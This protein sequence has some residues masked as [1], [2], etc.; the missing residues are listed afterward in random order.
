MNKYLEKIAAKTDL[1]RE[2]EKQREGHVLHHKHNGAL[3]GGYLAGA[4]Y[5]AYSLSRLLKGRPIRLNQD[6]YTGLASTVAG[7]VVG[8]AVGKRNGEKTFKPAPIEKEA[9]FKTAWNA[10]KNF[11]RT[12]PGAAKGA[13]T[14][15]VIGGTLGGL[16]KKDSVLDNKN[17][18]RTVKRTTA[19]RV[20]SALSGAVT[21]AYV[22]TVI[23]SLRDLK[24]AGGF[25]GSSGKASNEYTSRTI[26]DIHSDLSMPKGG[27]K[28]KTEAKSHFRKMRSQYHPDKHPG[29]EK[30][31][32]DKMAKFNRAWDEFE[33]HPQGFTKL[34]NAYLDKIAGLDFS[35]IK[36]AVKA[37]PV[38]TGLGAAMGLDGLASTTRKKNEAS[39]KFR[40]RQL[41]NTV[42]GVG[43]G[44][45]TGK[46]IQE[47][48]KHFKKN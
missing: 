46:I 45:V 39:G 3:I 32:N 17:E 9:K 33:K 36:A 12:Q 24:R 13:V 2:V 4:A 8:S 6:L 40:L 10:A 42:T 15:A 5:G 47:G 31:M 1:D 28:T 21:G 19:A 20:A 16:R 29:K 44:A 48:Y 34:A 22:G 26:H 25:R 35:K 38:A 27:F 14:G 18:V 11:A 7:S 30:E 23:G 43:A 41:R 37:N